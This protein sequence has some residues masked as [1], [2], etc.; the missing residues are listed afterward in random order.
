MLNRLECV[1][2]VSLIVMLTVTTSEGQSTFSSWTAGLCVFAIVSMIFYV[3]G[4]ALRLQWK[5]ARG[6]KNVASVDDEAYDPLVEDEIVEEVMD[7]RTYCCASAKP[8]AK[9]TAALVS[10]EP[11]R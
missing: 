1:V 11:K 7:Y 2:L 6:G 4:R 8:S 5:S 9:P 3:V 10:A